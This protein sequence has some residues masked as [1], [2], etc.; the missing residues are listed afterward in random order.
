VDAIKLFGVAGA[1]RYPSGAVEHSVAIARRGS[2][3]ASVE[4]VATER[5]RERYGIVSGRF[6]CSDEVTAKKARS[7]GYQVFHEAWSSWKTF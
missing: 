5:A 1:P 6:D 7:A 3:C 2:N 4:Y